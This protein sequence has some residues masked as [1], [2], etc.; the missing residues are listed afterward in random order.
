MNDKKN[1]KIEI[2]KN[3]ERNEIINFLKESFFKVIANFTI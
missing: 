1:Y 2:I 3:E